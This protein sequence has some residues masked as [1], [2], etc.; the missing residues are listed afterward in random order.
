MLSEQSSFSPAIYTGTR[1]SGKY[2]DQ[3][4]SVTFPSADESILEACNNPFSKASDSKIMA[5]AAT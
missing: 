3:E 5:N 1:P 4:H 2:V